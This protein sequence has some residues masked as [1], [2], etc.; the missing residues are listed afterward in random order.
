MLPKE[1]LSALGHQHEYRGHWDALIGIYRT[2][3]IR[4]YLHGLNGACYRIL[5]ASSVQLAS[6]DQA[7]NFFLHHGFHD[8]I[9]VHFPSSIIS[10]LFLVVSINP[11]D[12]VLTRLQNQKYE[13]GKGTLYHGW[14]DCVKKIARTEGFSGF[15]KGI[16][17]H[18]SRIAPQTILIFGLL[19]QA[20]KFF[21]EHDIGVVHNNL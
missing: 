13:A 18:Y 17:P 11:L 7:K 20:K 16:L 10:S 14:S 19:E 2:E 1:A 15:Y 3:G 6:Y 4:G 12:V 21:L 9:F 8:N 5:V